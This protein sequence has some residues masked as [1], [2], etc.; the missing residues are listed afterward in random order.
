MEKQFKCIGKLV[1]PMLDEHEMEIENESFIVPKDSVWEL[2]KHA[3]MGDVRLENDELGWIE[4]DFDS[5]KE[6]FVEIS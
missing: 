2:S 6:C 5:L 1:L 4:I 3:G